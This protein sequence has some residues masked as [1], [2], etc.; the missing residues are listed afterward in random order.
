E[1]W[2]ARRVSAGY[3]T[4]L[5]AR[6]LR[7]RYFTDAEVA[8]A[9]IDEKA[10]TGS[11][12]LVAIINETATRRYFPGE[13]PLGK[14]IAFGGPKSPPRQI[15]GI[16]ADI[17][18]GPPQTPEHPAAYVPF[19][20][21]DFGLVVRV[22]RGGHDVS[23]SLV[24][25]IRQVRSDLLVSRPTTMA[26]SI[27]RSPAASL[28][29]SS[30]WV[31]GGFATVAFLL[32]VV[33]LYGVVAYT[34]GQRTREI[35]VRMALGAQRQSVY[36]LVLGEAVSLVAVGTALGTACAVG[37]VAL[38]RN[39]LFDVQSWDVPTVTT[40]AAVLIVSGLAASYIPARRAAS[41]SPVEVLRVE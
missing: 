37:V 25:A 14:S 30:A 29:R 33:G 10:P 20:Y 8:E 15:I 19:T 7:G 26:E 39:L 24:A 40:A 18:E 38:M 3:F 11:R 22:S 31:I 12:G 16:V 34:V 41:V 28:H 23:P 9:P 36:R 1:D 4:A 32:S 6:L 21:V 35:G 2:P 27:D 5:Q 17:K 13:N